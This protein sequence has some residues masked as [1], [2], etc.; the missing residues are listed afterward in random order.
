MSALYEVIS[1]N[2]HHHHHH[3]HEQEHILRKRNKEEIETKKEK[4]EHVKDQMPRANCE[5]DSRNEN[6]VKMC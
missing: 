6:F 2:H 1:D 5:F 4:I 3:H